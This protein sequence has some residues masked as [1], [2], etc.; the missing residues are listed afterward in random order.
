MIS[1]SLPPVFA[2]FRRITHGELFE[3][4]AMSYW[5]GYN[6]VAISARVLESQKRA[7][8]VVYAKHFPRVV[9]VMPGMIHV[10]VGTADEYRSI[11]AI[12][13]MASIRQILGNTASLNPVGCFGVGT[14]AVASAFFDAATA[15]SA[16]LLADAEAAADLNS[17]GRICTF[18][19]HSQGAA[20]AD[21]LS[22]VKKHLVPTKPIRCIKFASPRVGSANYRNRRPSSLL[23]AGIYTERDMLGSMPVINYIGFTG[24]GLNPANALVYYAEDSPTSTIN[25]NGTEPTPGHE[26]FSDVRWIPAL[27]FYTHTP[28]PSNPFYTHTVD[29]YKM[30]MT[31]WA[32]AGNDEFTYRM[33]YL[34][35]EDDHSFPTLWTPGAQIVPAKAT[36]EPFPLDVQPINNVVAAMSL[37]RDGGTVEGGDWGGNEDP[38]VDAPWIVGDDWGVQPV[39][40]TSTNRQRRT[41]RVHFR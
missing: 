41:R 38:A 33:K 20:V 28:L 17:V 29:Y 7:W 3:A 18:T 30:L 36:G 8:G 32:V 21:I 2:E 6:D 22:R 5:A 11:F 27:R 15:C 35:W 1:I 37:D 26:F 10:R 25:H 12:E 39:M 14:S 9:D 24:L 16:A 13:G 31:A 40:V 23:H 4:M 34:E 19:G